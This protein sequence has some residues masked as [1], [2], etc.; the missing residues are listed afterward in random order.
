MA[1]KSCELLESLSRRRRVQRFQST[2]AVLSISSNFDA[3]AVPKLLGKVDMAFS[4]SCRKLSGDLKAA[5][6][7]ICCC[8]SSAKAWIKYEPTLS[9]SAGE[10]ELA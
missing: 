9:T 5:A 1:G 8:I 2:V 7:E 6:A 10:R 4:I 3:A